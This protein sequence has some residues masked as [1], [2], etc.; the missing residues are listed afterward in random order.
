MEA[1]N[2]PTTQA[3]A[4]R[5]GVA[6]RQVYPRRLVETED[7][8]TKVKSWPLT[9]FYVV[10]ERREGEQIVFGVSWPLPHGRLVFSD[11]RE[12]STGVTGSTGR[13]GTRPPCKAGRRRTMTPT[14][15]KAEVR[16]F[17]GEEEADRI[18]RF[19]SRGKPLF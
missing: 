16:R 12:C 3:P 8:E 13:W 4:W 2:T 1:V 17:I 19:L 6:W 10:L 11:S 14:E 18:V 5:A 15:W 9:L 7:G